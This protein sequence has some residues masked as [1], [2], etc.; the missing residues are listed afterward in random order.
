MAIKKN[1][2]VTVDLSKEV[3]ENYSGKKKTAINFIGAE[4]LDGIEIT[5]DGKSLFFKKGGN[6][7]GTISNAGKIKSTKF[8]AESS[9]TTDVIAQNVYYTGTYT[10]KKGK[11]SGSNYNDLM[12]FSDSETY[13]KALNIK[14]GNGY[15]TI[16]ATKYS[17]TISGGKGENIITIKNEA[18]GNDTINLTKGEKLTLDMTSYGFDNLAELVGHFEVKKKDLVIKTE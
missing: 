18:F 6:L 8:D 9:Y 13:K 12:D 2:V 5:S 7:I 11:V 10:P 16:T 15:D 17:D 1:Q 4:N 3:N 14:A